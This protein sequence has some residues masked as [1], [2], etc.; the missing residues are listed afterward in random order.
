MTFFSCA[1]GGA[2]VYAGGLLRDAQVD[3]SRIFLLAS[4]NVLLCAGLLF[5]LRRRKVAPLV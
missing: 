4:A 1:I 5:L 2:G 3:V